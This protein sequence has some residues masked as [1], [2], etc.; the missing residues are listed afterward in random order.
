MLRQFKFT[1]LAF[2]DDKFDKK[3]EHDPFK[4]FLAIPHHGQLENSS[5][6]KLDVV[7]SL[8]YDH[9]P[10][11][12]ATS[13]LYDHIPTDIAT[14]TLSPP[15]EDNFE[16]FSFPSSEIA[17]IGVMNARYVTVEMI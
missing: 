14:T 5:Y 11:D 10:A 16:A 15:K 13:L 6:T 17:G 1:V 2:Y 7:T 9:I 3:P 8:L 4:D 12:T